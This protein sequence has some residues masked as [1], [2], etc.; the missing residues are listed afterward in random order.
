MVVRVVDRPA[1]G[2]T[3]PDYFRARMGDKDLAR[4]LLEAGAVPESHRE[5]LAARLR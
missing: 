4:Q 1:H 3:V 2:L 5:E